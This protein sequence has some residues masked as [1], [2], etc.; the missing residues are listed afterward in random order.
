MDDITN[1][2]VID[3]LIASIESLLPNEP[4]PIFQSTVG[5][6]AAR[7]VPSGVGA[8]VGHAAS[9][10]EEIFGRH[11]EGEVV[12]T[13]KRGN[14]GD[15]RTAIR[16]NTR[17]LMGIGRK[18]LLK[19]GILKFELHEVGSQVILTSEGEANQI[20]QNDLSFEILYEFLKQPAVA[21]GIIQEIPINQSV[22]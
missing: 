9:V 14:V 1:I 17:I 16:E 5:I 12:V 15:L 19:Q 18:E 2:E 20:F 21:E 11:L 3:A 4:N 8:F 6:K 13:V 22:G 7:I 10:T